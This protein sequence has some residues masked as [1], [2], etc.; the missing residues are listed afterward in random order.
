MTA[1]GW[2][3]R[4]QLRTQAG[5][6][7]WSLLLASLPPSPAAGLVI[8]PRSRLHALVKWLR[9]SGRWKPSRFAYPCPRSTLVQAALVALRSLSTQ[10]GGEHDRLWLTDALQLEVAQKLFDGKMMWSDDEWLDF[11]LQTGLEEESTDS[12]MSYSTSST[13]TLAAS[14]TSSRTFGC[15]ELLD[16]LD[17][18]EAARS[19]PGEQE[20]SMSDEKAGGSGSQSSCQS[21]LETFNNWID[22]VAALEESASMPPGT[23]YYKVKDAR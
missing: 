6:Q 8:L 1:R 16:E 23:R 12:N 11:Q 15:K 9:M 4:W 7:T 3:P 5:Q 19:E 18:L 14:R 2:S 10:V 13:G 17:D 21:P 22:E 20:D